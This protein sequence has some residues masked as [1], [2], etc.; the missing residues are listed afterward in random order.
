ME[1]KRT[2]QLDTFIDLD[3]RKRPSTTSS[4]WMGEGV[5]NEIAKKKKEARFKKN[6]TKKNHIHTIRIKL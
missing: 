5:F 2:T 6:R 3:L 4:D 1:E